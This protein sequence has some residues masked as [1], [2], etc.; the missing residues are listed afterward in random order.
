M[1]LALLRC[2]TSIFDG[3]IC[4]RIYYNAKTFNFK[5]HEISWQKTPLKIRWKYAYYVKSQGSKKSY[6]WPNLV[7]ARWSVLCADVDAFKLSKVNMFFCGRFLESKIWKS[8]TGKHLEDNE[9]WKAV[10]MALKKCC[11]CSGMKRTVYIIV[12]VTCSTLSSA[13]EGMYTYWPPTF[14]FPLSKTERRN[15]NENIHF[16]RS[17]EKFLF[18]ISIFLTR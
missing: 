6:T 9:E 1:L 12:L 8:Y 10:L 14:V 16:S 11:V 13:R 18:L 15:K 17:R 5:W 2:Y 7:S 3:F 4:R